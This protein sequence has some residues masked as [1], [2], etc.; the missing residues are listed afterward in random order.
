MCT[1][2]TQLTNY[3][4]SD[5]E[6]N[7]SENDISDSDYE[8]ETSNKIY[9]HLPICQYQELS[10][11]DKPNDLNYGSRMGKAAEILC[12]LTAICEIIRISIEVLELLRSQNQLKY[13]D[14][15]LT[16]IRNVTRFIEN[17]YPSS[18]GVLEMQSSSCNLAGRLVC[19]HLLKMLLAL[20]D[21]EPIVPNVN[22]NKIDS[23]SSK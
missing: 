11:I 14:T 5:D 7:G 17:K 13:K 9:E 22:K 6:N 3:S 8:D 1:N 16:F 21:I 20:Y 10:Q 15:S 18:N 4:D 2:I 19:S 23:S 12:N